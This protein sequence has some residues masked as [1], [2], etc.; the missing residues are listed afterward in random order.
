[1]DGWRD[2]RILLLLIRI[3]IVDMVHSVPCGSFSFL[4]LL[5]ER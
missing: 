1:M 4:L 2:G 5:A 3:V